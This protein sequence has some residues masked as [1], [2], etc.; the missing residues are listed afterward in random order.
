MLR[1]LPPT[2]PETSASYLAGLSGFSFFDTGQGSFHGGGSGALMSVCVCDRTDKLSGQR[3]SPGL[4][5]VDVIVVVVAAAA[6]ACHQR[7]FGTIDLR[8]PAVLPSERGTGQLVVGEVGCC[9]GGGLS[10]C[11]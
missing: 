4:W 6:A 5:S 2:T 10:L 8:G 7:T 9:H 3:L 1:K 11:R